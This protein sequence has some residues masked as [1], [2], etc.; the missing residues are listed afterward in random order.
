MKS[1]NRVTSGGGTSG[2]ASQAAA[3]NPGVDRERLEAGQLRQIGQAFEVA[4]GGLGPP[5]EAQVQRQ[6]LQRADPRQALQP[7]Q[8]PETG[9]RHKQLQRPECGQR[10]QAPQS[11]H[12]R[13]RSTLVETERQRLERGEPAPVALSTGGEAP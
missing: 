10:G 2:T 12:V 1:L 11:V 5:A 3:A 13:K 6:E 9:S 8:A 7:G 4:S